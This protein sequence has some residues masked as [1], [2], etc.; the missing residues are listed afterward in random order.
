[1]VTPEFILILQ[2]QNHSDLNS[3]LL[4]LVK[5]VHP[6]LILEMYRNVFLDNLFVILI[7]L[8]VLELLMEEEALELLVLSEGML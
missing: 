6:L 3:V 1:M 7:K 5:N 2:N 4:P 8:V